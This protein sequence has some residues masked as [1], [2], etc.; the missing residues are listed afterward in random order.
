MKEIV[1]S[2]SYILNYWPIPNYFKFLGFKKIIKVVYM[3][4]YKIFDEF[5]QQ[6]MFINYMDDDLLKRSL[7]I[8]K[9]EKHRRL[10]IKINKFLKFNLFNI[11]N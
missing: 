8:L 10:K 6:R 2:I 5:I 11:H 9:Q 4:K 1:N 3:E 7:Y